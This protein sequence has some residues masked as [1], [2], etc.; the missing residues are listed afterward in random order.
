MN[1][2]TVEEV[3]IRLEYISKSVDEIKL[4]MKEQ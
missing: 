1:K 3:L 2:P 4:L